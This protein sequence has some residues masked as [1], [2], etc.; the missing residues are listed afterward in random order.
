MCWLL[1]MTGVAVAVVLSVLV[2]FMAVQFQPS[3]SPAHP[4]RSQLQPV[5]LVPALSI[6]NEEERPA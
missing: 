3:T 4:K 2:V 5:A 6:G 1:W